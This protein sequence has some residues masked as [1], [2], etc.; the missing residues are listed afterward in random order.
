MIR[1]SKKAPLWKQ[2]QNIRL[3]HLLFT[4]PRTAALAW[5]T[6]SS[7]V[8]P[9]WWIGENSVVSLIFSFAFW[10]FACLVKE[11]YFCAFV[12]F[13][14]IKMWSCLFAEQYAMSWPWK[15]YCSGFFQVKWVKVI[16]V[17][18]LQ[19]TNLSLSRQ[20]LN[21]FKVMHLAAF[22]DIIGCR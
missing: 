2:N 5:V 6:W 10:L 19:T 20:N 18:K 11:R 14:C 8:F 3:C 13:M 4:H 22:C 9:E 7:G 12:C 15:S 17:K 21:L 1:W 16:K